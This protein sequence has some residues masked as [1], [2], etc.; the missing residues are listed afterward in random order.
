MA[1]SPGELLSRRCVSLMKSALRPEMWPRTELK[2]Q[3]FDKLLM[4]VVRLDLLVLYFFFLTFIFFYITESWSWF[5][6]EL[7]I[8]DFKID[9]TVQMN[10]NSRLVFE[11]WFNWHK[12]Y[13]C[14]YI[15]K[16]VVQRALDTRVS[17]VFPAEKCSCPWLGTLHWCFYQS[18]M[19]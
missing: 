14:L 12:M 5:R 18:F 19:K 7:T 11:K 10:A 1:G 17:F 4:T 13:M 9:S 16:N 2:L 8:T 3:W 15:L 6:F